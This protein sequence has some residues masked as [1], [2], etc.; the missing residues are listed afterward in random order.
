MTTNSRPDER[1][2]SWIESGPTALAPADR[3]AIADAAEG[4]RQRR[5]ITLPW[6][7]RRARRLLPLAVAMVVVVVA[8]AVI[9]PRLPRSLV[10]GPEIT[11]RAWIQ[12]VVNEAYPAPLRWEPMFGVRVQPVWLNS[13]EDLWVH[14]DAAADGK[15][16][17]IAFIDL[18]EVAFRTDCWSGLRATCIFF[19]L[20]GPVGRPIVD[21]SVEW[22]AFGLVID[23][24]GDGQGDLRVGI[25]NAPSDDYRTWQTDLRTGV[26]T[27]RTGGPY[28]DP[29][30]RTRSMD[31]VFPDHEWP[32]GDPAPRRAHFYFTRAPQTPE[33]HFYVWTALIRNGELVSMDFAPDSGWLQGALVPEE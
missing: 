5:G 16:R 11:P 20:A 28:E 17:P 31:T 25:D 18:V 29:P 13:V 2:A 30:W 10:G 33:I 14:R 6:S 8:T 32:A 26:T 21:P 12:E 7:D 23:E 22:M 4:I 19:D 24:D 1:I 3:A 15:P 27:A 9:L